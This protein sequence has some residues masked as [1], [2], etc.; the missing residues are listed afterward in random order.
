MQGEVYGC[1][2]FHS[3]ISTMIS[4]ATKLSSHSGDRKSEAYEN[5]AGPLIPLKKTHLRTCLLMC[6]E[7]LAKNNYC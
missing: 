5:Q 7:F 1:D 6:C 3:K 2:G 4:R